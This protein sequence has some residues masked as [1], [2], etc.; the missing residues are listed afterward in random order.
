M[1]AGLALFQVFT[2]AE[3][4]F[5]TGLQG[6]FGFHDQFLVGL[7]IVLAALGVAENG[8]LAADGSEHAYGHLAG[9]GAFLMI[10]AVLGAELDLGALQDI[11]HAGQMG[12]RRSH[13]E[14]DIGGDILRFFYDCFCKFYTFGNSGVHFPVPCYDKFSHSINII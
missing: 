8:V 13:D 5:Q 6:Q 14:F 2:H 12:E 1:L 10:G 3:D 9:V 7:A 4:D 11:G